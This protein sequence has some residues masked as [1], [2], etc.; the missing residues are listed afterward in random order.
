MRSS[1]PNSWVPFSPI[2]FS[3]PTVS[4]VWLPADIGDL[5]TAG[6][7]QVQVR[8]DPSDGLHLCHPAIHKQFR[9]RDVAAVAGCEKYDGIGNLIRGAEP[10]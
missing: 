10:S 6:E 7:S 1:Q 2:L 9:S 5:S 3:K 4:F 8:N